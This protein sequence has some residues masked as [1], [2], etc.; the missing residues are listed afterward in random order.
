M[1]CW[2]DRIDCSAQAG[3][4]S[5]AAATADSISSIVV[6]GAREITSFVALGKTKTFSRLKVKRAMS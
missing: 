2:R 6:S 3:K 5:L 4:A 1:T